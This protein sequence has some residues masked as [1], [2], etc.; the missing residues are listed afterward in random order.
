MTETVDDEVLATEDE[1]TGGLPD[2]SVPDMTAAILRS[3]GLSGEPITWADLRMQPAIGM[4]RMANT[5]FAD[6]AGVQSVL[7]ATYGPGTYDAADVM[8]AHPPSAEFSVTGQDPEVNGVL[9]GDADLDLPD[10]LVVWDFGDGTTVRG[11][12]VTHTY[13]SAGT[14]DITCTVL[15]AGT[16]YT[17]V[18]PH[19]IPED[20]LEPDPTSEP[21]AD[22]PYDPGEHTVDEVLAYCAEHPDEVEAIYD[23]EEAG[24][25]RVTLLDKLA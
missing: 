15:V 12:E 19:E 16:A 2:V 20:V 6:A 4:V 17:T 8:L 18:Q 24:K 5:G 25:N 9:T 22:G 7:D 13:T 10:E 21:P 3:W 1:E 11:N 14:F 23:A